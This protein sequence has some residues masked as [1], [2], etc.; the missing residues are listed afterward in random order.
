MC[1][2]PFSSAMS[3]RGF[4]GRKM[5]AIMAVLVTRGSA[6]I[7]VAPGFSNSLCHRMG[8]FSAMC[9]PHGGQRVLL[10]QAPGAELAAIHGVAFIAA[11]GHCA[12]VSH[13]DQ[14]AASDRAIAAGSG[15]PAVRH[16]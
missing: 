2:I 11:R 10:A 1:A 6:T 7:K 13:A 9:A 16:A 3:E 8:W 14:P 15:D 5:S 12:P 4:K